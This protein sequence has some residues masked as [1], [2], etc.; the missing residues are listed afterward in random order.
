MKSS[1][2]YLQSPYK[3]QCSDYDTSQNPFNSV[4]REDC[5]HKCVETNYYIKYKCFDRHYEYIIRRL[6]ESSFDSKVECNENEL[7]NCFNVSKKCEKV[8]P[9][10][11]LRERNFFKSHVKFHER[12]NRC[13]NYYFW[14]LREV[15]ISYEETA[16]ILLVDY[17]IYIGGLFGLWFGIYFESLL[18]LIVKHTRNLKTKVN[19]QVKKISSFIYI[20]SIYISILHCIHDSIRNFMNYMLEKVLSI[21]N[22][23]IRLGIWFSDWLQFLIDLIITQLKTLCK[24]LSFLS[25]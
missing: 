3:S 10:E 21:K 1:V 17:F 18:D 8:C 14:D 25:Q 22:K 24:R 2:T 19:L 4:S 12:K 20:F 15:F 7:K 13:D 23:I 9:I 11:C 16:D 6:D 5:L